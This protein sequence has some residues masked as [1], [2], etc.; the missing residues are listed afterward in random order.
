MS[1]NALHA[2]RKVTLKAG[3]IVLR[4]SLL[5]DFLLE[6]INFL[7]GPATCEPVPW[8]AALSRLTVKEQGESTP[9]LACRDNYACPGHWAISPQLI[10]EITIPGQDNNT[11]DGPDNGAQLRCTLTSYQLVSIV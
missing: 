7:R 9:H 2:L 1:L 10:V 5:A 8:H 3:G 11:R 4:A 6:I